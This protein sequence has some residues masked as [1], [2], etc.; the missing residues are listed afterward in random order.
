VRRGFRIGALQPTQGALTIMKTVEVTYRYQRDDSLVR[1]R[2][3]DA[4]AARRRL[5]EGNRSF[6]ELLKKFA[7]GE[8]IAQRVI[9][10][11]P[12]DLG[13][14][15]GERHEPKQ[16]PYAAVLGCSDARVPIELIFS[17][18]PNDLFVVRIAG[19]GLGSDTLGS[20]KY[21]V[22]HLGKSIKLVAILGH[23]GCGAVSAAVDI[24]LN[25]SGYFAIA[26]EYG[27][28]N[29]LD[30]LLV[31]VRA[32]AEKMRLVF[33]SEVTNHRRY[34]EALIEAS[35][36]TNV[37]LTAYTVQQELA[38]RDVSGSI[39][40][41][42]GVYVLSSHEIW[43]PRCGS[44]DHAGLADPPRDPEEFVE[45]G[46]VVTRSDRITAILE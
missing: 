38:T 28:R 24:F 27:L 3:V 37:A 15:A 21:A 40:A 26:S 32:S 19:N 35:V 18:G 12:H 7:E 23:S 42:Y 43:A 45:F 39:S 46:D 33:G 44:R 29:L 1:E 11:D 36:V 9:S 8:G 10:V 34:R 6:A 16:R 5:D 4:N 20:L 22:D 17:E 30:R 13:L 25:P 41:V 14:L 31:V 2:P